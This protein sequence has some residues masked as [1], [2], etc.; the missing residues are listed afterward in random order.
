MHTLAGESAFE[1]FKAPLMRY[2]GITAAPVDEVVC[3]D[4]RP[5]SYALGETIDGLLGMDLL[6][7]HTISID[8]DAG[9]LEIY[10]AAGPQFGTPVPL[11]WDHLAAFRIPH[12]VADFGDGTRQLLK[13]DT[14]FGTT[15]A[16]GLSAES[17][18]R[19]V[20]AGQLKPLGPHAQAAFAAAD[21]VVQGAL[22]RAD[23]CTV[24]ANTHNTLLFAKMRTGRLGLGYLSRY[25]VTFDF[26]N[27]VMYLRPGKG[28]PRADTWEMS[29]L[30]LVRSRE[31]ITVAAVADCSPGATA[32]IRNGDLIVAVGGKSV[33]N[34]S[35]SAFRRTV[36]SRQ[37][38]VIRVR[39]AKT[40]RDVVLDLGVSPPSLSTGK[41]LEAQREINKGS[42]V[43]P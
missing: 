26:P 9:R 28:F 14:G 41:T 2:G 17:Y 31:G 34:M 5:V 30:D 3:H 32:G 1:K 19:L 25:I 27:S 7:L 18:D 10:P 16:G 38:H 21:R 13:L 43:T 15:F 37:R 24:G 8:F 40:D 20:E 12:V 42:A 33:Q 22:A 23:R 11:E 35:L 6:C 4:L 29:G 36:A 39:R